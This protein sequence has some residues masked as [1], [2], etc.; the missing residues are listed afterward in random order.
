MRLRCYRPCD[1]RMVSVTEAGTLSLLW[2][3]RDIERSW[4][5]LRQ[6]PCSECGLCASRAP[7]FLFQSRTKQWM[8]QNVFRVAFRVPAAAFDHNPV[9]TDNPRWHRERPHGQG[10]MGNSQDKTGSGE[11]LP[12]PPPF[13]TRSGPRSL[14]IVGFDPRAAHR[15]PRSIPANRRASA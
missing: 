12:P 7:V 5:D 10:D 13:A 14:R 11:F 15:T 6:R 3:D 9:A 8:R 2:T 4:Q 1:G